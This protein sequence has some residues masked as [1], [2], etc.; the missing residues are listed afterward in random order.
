MRCRRQNLRIKMPAIKQEHCTTQ[1]MP[2]SFS[3]TM[4]L[5]SLNRYVRV[6]TLQM[7]PP[8]M[9]NTPRKM[10]SRGWFD[11]RF[12]GLC[13]EDYDAFFSPRSVA[14]GGV[15]KTGV[16]ISLSTGQTRRFTSYPTSRTISAARCLSRRRLAPHRRWRGRVPSAPPQS[17][18]SKLSSGLITD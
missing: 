12:M 18:S 8:T 14:A 9:S 15:W 11:M 7:N 2:L 5:S 3:D 16:S 10:G 1:M 4:R 13:G 17:P 6:Y